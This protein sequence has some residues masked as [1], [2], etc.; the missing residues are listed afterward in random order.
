MIKIKF[1]KKISEK[2]IEQFF[3]K[4]G[5]KDLIS[6]KKFYVDGY[7]VTKKDF[8]DK[9]KDKTG[10]FDIRLT[11]NPQPPELKDLYRLYQFII[12]NKRTTILEF[13]CGYSTLI[14]SHALKKLKNK[15]KR[16]PF[17]RCFHPFKLFVVDSEKKYIDIVKKRLNKF[18]VGQNVNYLYSKS[19][20]VLYAGNYATEYKKIPSVNPDFIYL[21]GPDHLKIK[22]SMNNFKVSSL[23]MMPMSCDILKIENYLTPGTIILID[24]RTSNARYLKN[25]FK[26]NWRE[27]FDSIS[28]QTIFLLDEKPLG[29]FNKEQIKFYNTI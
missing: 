2:K 7:E 22:G 4:E 14:I 8:K 5:L 24:G 16:K 12:L 6:K 17:T 29:R 21:D 26:R 3:I 19:Q 25:N 10:K 9:K 18:S 1:P 23:D 20:M 13:G 11:N 15:F 28:D 27:Y